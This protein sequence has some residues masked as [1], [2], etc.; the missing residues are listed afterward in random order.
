MD[1]STL[2]EQAAKLYHE[3]Y[4]PYI[5]PSGRYSILVGHFIGVQA[6]QDVYNGDYETEWEFLKDYDQTQ[7][8][9]HQ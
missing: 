7:K 8:L 6:K 9:R 4:A 5:L 1:W 2:A 3:G